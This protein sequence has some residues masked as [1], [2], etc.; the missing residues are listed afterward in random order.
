[1]NNKIMTLFPVIAVRGLLVITLAVWVT[2]ATASGEGEQELLHAN[3]D[4]TNQAS[5][6]RG[7]RNFINYCMGCHSLKYMRYNQL[8]KGLG[9]TEDQLIDNLMFAA[10]KPTDM[11]TIAMPPADAARWFGRTPPDLTLIGRSRGADF[12]Y[13]F[14]KSFYIEDSSP[15]GVNNR[16]LGNLSMPHVLWELQGLQKPVYEEVSAEDGRTEQVFKGFEPVTKGTLSPEEYDQFVR[17]IVN[18]LEYV[19]EPG[20]VA[21]RKLGVLVVTFLLVFGLFAYMLKKEFW[22]D[23]K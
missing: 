9:I 23:V 17:D 6:Q 13:T 4:V 15:T 14:L 5:L 18:F 10:E 11:M 16:M 1:M 20:Q 22:K 8:A 21:R 7:A 12:L 3:N 19:G 2:T